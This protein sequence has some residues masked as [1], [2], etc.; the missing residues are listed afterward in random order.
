K[1]KDDSVM[2]E[3]PHPALALGKVRH[4]GDPVAMVI[5]ATKA[6]AQDAAQLVQVD[7]EPL[8]A[9]A[10]LKDAAASGAPLVW[11]EAPGNL[12]FDW[13]L[14]D[15]AATDAGFSGAAHVT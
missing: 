11:D 13:E 9:V 4:A 6:Q 12:C 3:P 7:Y 8:P 5:A 10:H 15:R 14:G 1:N 2:V